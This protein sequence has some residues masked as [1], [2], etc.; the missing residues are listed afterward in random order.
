MV[1]IS[2][3]VKVSGRYICSLVILH[4]FVLGVLRIA[5][6]ARVVTLRLPAT[7][8]RVA[9]LRS[10]VAGCPR[11]TIKVVRGTFLSSSLFVQ[12]L[13]AS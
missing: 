7:L 12:Y 4:A 9:T 13:Y 3:V 8:R 6:R 1:G 2:V 11:V 10:A 5:A